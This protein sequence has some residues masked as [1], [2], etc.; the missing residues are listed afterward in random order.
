[1]PKLAKNKNKINEN[2][3][4]PNEPPFTIY[5]I[6][7]FKHVSSKNTSYIMYVEA[8]V[9]YVCIRYI[10][11]PQCSKPSSMAQIDDCLQIMLPNVEFLTKSSFDF[12]FVAP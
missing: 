9:W 8:L 3:E 5:G 4:N 6:G 10:V 1:M 12:C 7:P 2:L 11:H